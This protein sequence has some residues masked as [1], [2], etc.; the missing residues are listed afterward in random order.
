MGC[1]KTELYLTRRVNRIG[2]IRHPRVGPINPHFWFDIFPEGLA[3][4]HFWIAP[5]RLCSGIEA[6][7]SPTCGTTLY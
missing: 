1:G 5:W 7:P 4:Y 2:G 6:S 3:R